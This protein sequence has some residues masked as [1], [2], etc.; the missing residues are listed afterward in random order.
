MPHMQTHISHCSS[1][2]QIPIHTLTIKA[3][4][5]KPS[6]FLWLHVLVNYPYVIPG[7]SRKNCQMRHEGFWVGC[8]LSNMAPGQ[9]VFPNMVFPPLSQGSSLLLNNQILRR[10][11]PALCLS[12]HCPLTVWPGSLDSSL[13]LPLLLTE[14]RA[15]PSQ[16]PNLSCISTFHPVHI[17]K[18]QMTLGKCEEKR[19]VLGYPI[20]CYEKHSGTFLACTFATELGLCSVPLGNPGLLVEGRGGRKGPLY[21]GGDTGFWDRG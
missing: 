16:L 9:A 17:S 6:L 8:H 19:K 18:V 13:V 5:Y 1:C 3:Q 4:K 11:H 7:V 14:F 15:D 20:V 21:S 12:V 10:P 2:Y